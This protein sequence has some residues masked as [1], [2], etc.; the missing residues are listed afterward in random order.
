LKAEDIPKFT[1]CL[2]VLG[3]VFNEQVSELRMEAYR[4]ALSGY[5]LSAI[6]SAINRAIGTLKFFPKPAELIELMEGSHDDRAGQA[7]RVFLEAV[8]DGG[9]ASVK[10]LDPA[11]ATAV[12]VTFG[13]YLQAARTIREA[14]EPMV[15]HY[16]KNFMQ[17]YQTARKFPRQ[18]ETYRAG[19]F[20]FQNSGGGAWSLRM[21]TY[22]S[23]VRLIGLREVKEVRLPFDAQTGKLTDDA[24]LMIDAATTAEGAQQLLAAAITRA[25]KMLPA[26]ASESL[27]HNEA[28]RFL[29]AVEDQTGESSLKVMPAIEET[30]EEYQAR[31]RKYREALLASARE[32]AA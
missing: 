10:F 13:G 19:N 3:E 18:V 7:W 27:S 6:E 9:D 23:P 22:L 29:K 32:V 4:A 1:Q 17:A 2:L 25:P 11:A 16:R 31:V 12:D 14:D 5:E 24:R 8:S 15:A 30:E 20:E 21:T 26:P 28:T